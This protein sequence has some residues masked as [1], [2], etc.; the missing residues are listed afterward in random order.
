MVGGFLMQDVKVRYHVARKQH[1]CEHEHEI[2][3]GN[4]YW[5]EVYLPAHLSYFINE[6]E[7][8]E[9]E[10]LPFMTRKVCHLHHLMEKS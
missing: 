9:Y 7:G 3:P 8:W 1:Q 2:R 10:D 6:D 4:I 5:V